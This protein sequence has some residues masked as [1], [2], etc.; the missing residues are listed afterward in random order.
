MGYNFI[1][2]AHGVTSLLS[3]SH[4]LCVNHHTL[5]TNLLPSSFNQHG[6]FSPH[7]LFN[8]KEGAVTPQINLPGIF[9]IEAVQ[10][11]ECD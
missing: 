11:L 2:V 1:D 4:L 10:V 3:Y 9:D 8:E 5:M 6:T 7:S